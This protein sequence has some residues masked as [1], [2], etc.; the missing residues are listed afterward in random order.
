MLVLTI[1]IDWNAP[2]ETTGIGKSMRK[3]A[4]RFEQRV[5]GRAN[6]A[7]K[8]GRHRAVI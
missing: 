7:R 6:A 8:S 4:S 1:Y 5:K 3:V 2:F